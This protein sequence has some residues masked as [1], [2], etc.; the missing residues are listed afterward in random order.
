MKNIILFLLLFLSLL[1][2][3]VQAVTDPRLVTNN[4][5]GIHAL[6]LDDLEPAANLVNSTGGK[7]GYVTL[8]MREND[9]NKDKWQA[10]L[11]KCRDLKL[12]PIIRL[13]TTPIKDYWAK[14]NLDT[15]DTW[16]NFLGNLN[17]VIQNRYIIL[18]N[19]P[20]HA[21][22]WENNINPEEYAK[23][24]KVFATALKKSSTD[25]FILP[26]G[27]DTAAPNSK[28]TM[29]ATDYWSRMYQDD[30]EIFSLL[31]GW[32]SHSYPNPGFSGSVTDS[33]LGTLKSYQ[34]ELNHLSSFGLP[35]DIPVFITETGWVHKDG[36]ILGASTEDLALSNFY[37]SAFNSIW[38]QSNL[39]AITPFILSYAQPPFDKFAWQKPNSKE[40]YPH[41]YAVK[42]LIKLTGQPIQINNSQQIKNNIPEKL[43]EASSYQ[44]TITFK[45]TGQ[46]IWDQTNTSLS[47]NSN[48][49]EDSFL[50]SSI[51]KPTSPFSNTSFSITVNTPAEPQSVYLNLQLQNQSQNFGD[52]VTKNIDIIPPPSIIVKASRFLK[53]NLA[54]VTYKLLI[55]DQDQN[56][57]KELPI[58]L[59]K[60]ISQPI[61]LYNL[62]PQNHYRFVLLKPHYLPRQVTAIL[63]PVQTTIQFKRLLLLDF[64]QDGHFSIKDILSFFTHPI[65]SIKILASS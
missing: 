37:K 5:F 21:K 54:T 11:D 59:K 13:A 35:K 20:N 23:T 63:D 64:N 48:L 26:A 33:G 8:V 49:P 29:R 22:E 51:E 9:R 31:D 19:E 58:S 53:S 17:W 50:I 43:T 39:I 40:F 25:Y 7:W 56:L 65:Q 45:N 24:I 3:P 38:T 42:N 46:S 57:K 30:P 10:I 32:N 36:K 2:K 41:Y 47:I 6:D 61:K 14:P 52:I 27:L 60:S 16:V 15:V 12:I 55:Y 44:L 4:R 28:D 62:V 34:A 18:F 1:S